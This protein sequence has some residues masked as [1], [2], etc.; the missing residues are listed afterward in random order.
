MIFALLLIATVYITLL[1]YIVRFIIYL[2]R[3]KRPTKITT[4]YTIHDTPKR[5]KLYGPEKQVSLW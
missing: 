3:D 4:T 5:K 2:F 1:I